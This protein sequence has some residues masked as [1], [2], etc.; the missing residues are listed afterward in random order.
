VRRFYF[1]LCAIALVGACVEPTEP[2]ARL[3]AVQ[4]GADQGARWVAVDR[5]ACED[6]SG[7]TLVWTDSSLAIRRVEALPVLDSECSIVEGAG[8]VGGL[9]PEGWCVTVLGPEGVPEDALCLPLPG[10]PAD[11]GLLLLRDPILQIWTAALPWGLP[12]C[13]VAPF[14]GE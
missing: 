6:V 9:D 12:T 14:F 2:C 10:V 13:D 1:G 11:T 4:P 8:P 7:R 3:V 5:S